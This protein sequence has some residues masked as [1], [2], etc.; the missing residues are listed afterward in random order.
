MR[1]ANTVRFSLPTLPTTC[2]ILCLR[3][4]YQRLCR[5]GY[6]RLSPL[7]CS[8]SKPRYATGRYAAKDNQSSL[9]GWF[10]FES[11]E[12]TNKT[13]VV[14]T[15]EMIEETARIIAEERPQ[16]KAESA[17]VAPSEPKQ[18]VWI[19]ALPQRNKSER[20]TAGKRKSSA[21]DDFQLEPSQ[22][23]PKKQKPASNITGGVQKVQAKVC[24]VYAS[25][26]SKAKR[27]PTPP[28]CYCKR[29]FSSLEALA[30]HN[31]KC[32]AAQEQSKEGCPPVTRSRDG[33]VSLSFATQPILI[34]TYNSTAARDQP[35]V[36]PKISPE[37][38]PEHPDDVEELECYP[39]LQAG[40]RFDLV[41]DS[42]FP[43]GELN[44]QWELIPGEDH[45]AFGVSNGLA[46]YQF[47]IYQYGHGRGLEC[48]RCRRDAQICVCEDP[49]SLLTPGYPDDI[50]IRHV[51]GRHQSDG[52]HQAEVSCVIP[53][54]FCTNQQTQWDTIDDLASTQMTV[55]C[56]RVIE[57]SVHD[58]PLVRTVS[59]GY[60]RIRKGEG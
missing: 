47:E 21:F 25:S 15:D 26:R 14:V 57:S 8:R 1:F 24:D 3:F 60:C 55:V 4:E 34:Q 5:H 20:T 42:A 29:Y 52:A 30:E 22:K 56:I 44:D 38:P 41:F 54:T 32:T 59:Q 11:E 45:A 23:V 28:Q 35:M 36:Q 51:T 37:I 2:L 9:R 31:V 7:P 18:A 53:S 16:K 50:I 27:K 40:S 17:P 12:F 13:G 39:V 46:Q 58:V 19:A 6:I 49:S 43:I 10:I 48:L 33:E